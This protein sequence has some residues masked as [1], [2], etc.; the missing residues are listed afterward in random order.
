MD[1]EIKVE[2]VRY[3]YSIKNIKTGLEMFGTVRVN[4]EIVVD[5]EFDDIKPLILVKAKEQE[6]QFE[7][8]DDLE[9]R[10]LKTIVE[11]EADKE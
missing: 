2:F 3:E 5:V 11:F 9:I 7:N 1:E 8:A 6:A 4:L 10:L